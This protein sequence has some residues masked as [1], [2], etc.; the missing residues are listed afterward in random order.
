MALATSPYDDT[1]LNA[2]ESLY[3]RLTTSYAYYGLASVSN[4][5]RETA[6]VAV[7]PLMCAAAPAPNSAPSDRMVTVSPAELL[8]KVKPAR[9]MAF[10]AAPT[11]DP[12]EYQGE[13]LPVVPADAAKEDITDPVDLSGVQCAWNELSGN[14]PESIAAM[15]ESL[16]GE[17]YIVDLSSY[18]ISAVASS[19]LLGVSAVNRLILPNTI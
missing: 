9:M 14:L 5:H 6:S 12:F 10:A 7:A 18:N 17:E 2:D 1:I 4:I 3:A 19:A 8:A 13:E 11:A 16:A 15:A